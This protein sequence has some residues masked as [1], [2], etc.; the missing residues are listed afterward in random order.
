LTHARTDYSSF[1]QKY[2]EIQ[3]PDYVPDEVD[4]AYADVKS[5]GLYEDIIH[6]SERFR[7]LY[8]C[9]GFNRA[10][11]DHMGGIDFVVYTVDLTAYE[12]TVVCNGKSF[13]RLGCTIRC[14]RHLTLSSRFQT[15]GFIMILVNVE[16][17]GQRLLTSP[18]EAHFPA[19]DGGNDIAKATAFIEGQFKINSRTEVYSGE[20]WEELGLR[21]LPKILVHSIV[22]KE[23]ERI[24]IESAY[25]DKHT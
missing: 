13:N 24:L 5:P 3:Q 4:V 2:S 9:G 23:W 10:L 21:F 15:T 18:L 16:K 11:L 14:V 7:A 22:R 20:L 8:V 17:F 25:L 12:Q 6:L 19:Y 1:W